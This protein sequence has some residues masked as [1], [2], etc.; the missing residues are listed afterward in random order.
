[1]RCFLMYISEWKSS[2]QIARMDAA[3]ERG[4][5]R[6]LLDAA[7]S[8]DCGLPDDD[9]EL[10]TTSL[11]KK[12]WFRVT[13]DED[14]QYSGQTSGQKLRSCFFRF[15][16]GKAIN[17]TDDA[18]YVPNDKKH[19]SL[20][21]LREGRLYNERLLR[22][23]RHQKAV[24]E[25][26][27]VASNIGIGAK[28]KKAQG[29]DESFLDELEQSGDEDTTS[30]VPTPKDSPSI[31][32]VDQMVNQMD[33]HLANHTDNKLSLCLSLEE[34]ISI[35]SRF[36]TEQGFN[37]PKAFAYLARRY[38]EAGRMRL[39]IALPVFMTRIG[40]APRGD[41]VAL[42]ARMLRGLLQWHASHQWR[43]GAVNYIANWISE[44]LYEEHPVSA[45]EVD[46]QRAAQK[47]ARMPPRKPDV[48]EEARALAK[49]QAESRRAS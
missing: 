1:M 2:K 9:D 17:A 46:E 7:E 43:G 40:E 3:E 29:Q 4:Y 16:D 33:N 35:A 37:T 20:D 47:V 27:K 10:R 30:P 38:P 49:A 19:W 14:H 39:R 48:I 18:P 41:A 8:P 36:Q 25:T 11:L 22:E 23:F 6:L 13:Q 28:R 24:S 32:L 31:Q 42:F 34:S 5:L 44:Q 26:R 12:Q 45:G 21:G 15:K